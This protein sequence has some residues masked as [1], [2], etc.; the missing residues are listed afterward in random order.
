[1]I[2]SVLCFHEFETNGYFELTTKNQFD[3]LSKK[4]SK[5]LVKIFANELEKLKDDN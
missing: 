3:A 5:S 4:T 1:M 2:F